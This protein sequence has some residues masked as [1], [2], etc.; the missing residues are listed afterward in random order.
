MSIQIAGNYLNVVQ[1]QERMDDTVFSYIDTTQKWDKAYP[2]LDNLLNQAVTFFKDYVESSNGELPKSN[3]YWNL[4]MG[5]ASKLIYFNTVSYYRLNDSQ[6]NHVKEN[7]LGSLIYAANCLPEVC[8]EV[9]SE[10]LKEISQSYEEIEFYNGTK[11]AFEKMILAN[12]NRFD[13]CV[14]SFYEFCQIY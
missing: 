6:Q 10:F 5:I 2:S 1:L 13:D 8:N 3:T 7:V 4:F 9:N 11:G 14:K 12:N